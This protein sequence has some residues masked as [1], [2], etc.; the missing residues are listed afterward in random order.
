M[1]HGV[2]TGESLYL[3]Q[4]CHLASARPRHIPSRGS[5]ADFLL[6]H[7]HRIKSHAPAQHAEASRRAFSAAQRGHLMLRHSSGSCGM[8]QKRSSRVLPC[9]IMQLCRATSSESFLKGAICIAAY[10]PSLPVYVRRERKITCT[11]G[12]RSA[13]RE[14]PHPGSEQQR[15]EAPPVTLSASAAPP[16]RRCLKAPCGTN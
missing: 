10:A 3:G 11:W 4:F 16:R 2:V 8:A 9:A 1:R 7:A 14:C 6:T 5:A 15:I 12:S 13:P